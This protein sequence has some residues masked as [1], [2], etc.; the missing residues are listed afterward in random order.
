[1]LFSI[2]AVATL[3]VV[4][5][6]REYKSP[7]S[8]KSLSA[9]LKVTQEPATGGICD[10]TVK[11]SSGYFNVDSGG[12]HDA[13]YFYWMFESRSEPTNDPVIL[14][15][16][17]G[18]G[19]SSQLALMSENGPCTPTEDGMDTVNNPYSWTTNANMI[20]LDQPAGVGYSYGNGAVSS[21]AELSTFVLKLSFFSHTT[22]LPFMDKKIG[23]CPAQRRASGGGCLP[24][25]AG[26]LRAVPPVPGQ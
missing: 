18:P 4:S 21:I 15:L 17:G 6:R 8:G 2:F 20:W 1:M 7:V 13:N 5:A 14:W 16:T 23:R 3:L 24:L 11:Q 26:L 12:A 22:S 10:A 19:C 9:S 25:P